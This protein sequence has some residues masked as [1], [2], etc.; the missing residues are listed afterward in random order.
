MAASVLFDA[1]GPRTRSRHRVYTAI[2][3]VILAGIVGLVIWQLWRKDQFAYTYWEP[4]VTPN[5]VELLVKGL[6]KTLLAAVVAIAGAL[7]WGVVFGVAKL[8]EHRVLR[9][10][11]WTV[12]EF[13]RAVPLLM[14]IISTW[15][16][17]GPEPGPHAYWALVIG[18][19][20]Y[21]GAVFA[22]I[23]RA[24]INAVDRGQSEAAYALGMRKTMVM[25]LILVPQAIKIMLPAF[26]SQTIVALK[27]TSLGYA[28]LAPGLTYEGKIIFGTFRNTIQTA[29]VIAA[30]YILVNLMLSWLATKAQRRF[31]GEH[32]LDIV[33]GVVQRQPGGGAAGAPGP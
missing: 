2:S 19:V 13:F 32:K 20:L 25:R 14:L 27:D 28:I 9:W 31:A 21:N 16:F 8:S 10:P 3:S 12:V 24:G 4:F 5:I 6:G 17:I 30:I 23:F 29:V 18:L 7:V 22:E 1:P 33:G 15:F 26:I 11:A